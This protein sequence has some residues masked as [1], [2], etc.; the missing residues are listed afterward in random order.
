MAAVAGKLQRSGGRPAAPL[1]GWLAVGTFP[2]RGYRLH[3]RR[4]GF[5]YDAKHLISIMDLVLLC[6][7]FVS[8]GLL[9]I[10]FFPSSSLTVSGE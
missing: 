1:V 3:L 5:T 4:R 6:V 8:A 10:I 7:S 9:L 2:N